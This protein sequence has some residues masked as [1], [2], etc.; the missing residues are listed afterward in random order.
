MKIAV[1]GTGYVGLVTGTC[2]SEM[3]VRVTC[4]DVDERKIEALN[5][6]IIP[7]Y[8]P[9]LE[10]LVHKN[11]KSGRL[12]FTT[13]LED[14]I[15]DVDI[16]FSAV[17]TPPDEDGSADLKYVLDVAHTIGKHLNH[18]IVVVTKSTV[19][20]GTASKVKA[21]I[22]Q[23]LNQRGV[24]VEFDVASNPEFLKEGNAVKDF[25]SPDRVVVGV[26]SE[27]A[28]KLMARLYKPFMIVSDRLIFTDIPSAEMIKYAANS[29]LATRISFMNDIAN[30]CELVGADVNMV[31]K[32]IGSDTRIGKKFL[33][34]GCGYG[35]SC[36]PKDVK[37][38]I[39]TA[40][41][42]GY[43]MRVL[44]AVEEVNADQKLVLYRKL[45]DYYGGD[46]SQL[47]DKVIALWGLAFKPETDDMREAPSLVLIDLLLEA[48][49]TV[50]VYDPVAMEECRRR[51]GDRVTYCTD[52][53]QAA[54]G[55]DAL[56]LVTEWKE[57]RMPNIDTLLHKMRG[58]LILDGRNILDGEELKLA[59]FEYHCIGK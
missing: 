43:P 23:E 52:M 7:I 1:V 11:K 57:F 33:Y 58:R 51:I 48:G 22:Q 13:S 10:T 59:G 35:G 19:P 24:D 56:M 5:K 32:G 12:H 16:V 42:L 34:A 26:E 47:E 3:G 30:L 28:R 8:E 14:V 15:N 17:G 55:S 53:Y 2:F 37:A 9:G 50:K 21:V 44:Q 27:R 36:F 46:K 38:L 25:M 29:M 20:V 54:D 18:Y 6:G 49:A 41:D 31:R 40:A 39:K 4:V 45:V